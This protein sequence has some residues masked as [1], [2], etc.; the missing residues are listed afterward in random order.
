MSTAAASYIIADTRAESGIYLVTL[1]E[2]VITPTTVGFES[3]RSPNA[4]LKKCLNTHGF[5][6]NLTSVISHSAMLANQ[7]NCLTCRSSVG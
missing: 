1:E 6:M 4:R 7:M 3:A 2:V 5:L